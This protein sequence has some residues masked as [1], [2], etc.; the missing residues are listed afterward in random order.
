MQKEA[1][2][3]RYNPIAEYAVIGDCHTAALVSRTGAIDWYCPGRFDAPAVFCRLLDADRGGFFLVAPREVRATERRY[4]GPTNVLE[5][6]HRTPSGQ[7]RVI[8]LM[9]IYPRQEHREGYDVGCYGQILRLVEALEGD[10]EVEVVLKPTFGY[11][12]AR[13]ELELVGSGA[14]ARAGG[15]HL[16]LTV[17]GVELEP[18]S[19]CV[20]GRL[21][22]HAGQ[23]A[24]VQLT[25]SKGQPCQEPSECDKR[26]ASTLDYWRGWAKSCTYQG[27]YHDQV[28]RSALALKLLMYEPTGAYVAAPTTSLPEEIGG[29]RNWDYR[30]GWLRDASLILHALTSVGY[31]EEAVDFFSWLRNAAKRGDPQIMYAIDGRRDL[32]ETTL[33]H[34][35]GYRGSRPVRVG[36]AAF[37]QR[38]VDIYGEVLNAAYARYGQHGIVGAR[39]N[40]S[41]MSDETWALL[42]RFAD[43]AAREWREPDQGIWEVRGGPQRFLFSRVMCWVAL[44]RAVRLA[45]EFRLEAPMASWTRERANVRRAILTEAYDRAQGAF[46]QALGSTLIDA[47]ALVIPRVGFLPATDRRVQSTIERVRD[48]LGHSGLVCRY[49]THETDDGVPGGEA[50]FVLCSFWMVEALALAGRTD[51]ARE[52]FE[53]VIC[54]ANDVG[55]LSEEVAPETG[56]LLG[57]FPQGLSHLS[58]IGAAVTLDRALFESAAAAPEAAGGSG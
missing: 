51:E 30:Y 39:P 5:T 13:S 10:A 38:Q 3:G 27:L 15:E 49:R 37:C 58:L 57:N 45:K 22:L 36:N 47:S 20:V 7:V 41:G 4:A 17:D 54:H 50:T 56:E 46:T 33:E 44:D 48:V 16:R 21:R 25:S 19:G 40:E 6:I 31:R 24:W 12:Q 55:L 9:P 29:V 11:A 52:Q 43:A 42:R 34:L 8:D 2:T 14:I 28:L 23:R 32:S 26:L 18:A 35:E 53:R 1:A